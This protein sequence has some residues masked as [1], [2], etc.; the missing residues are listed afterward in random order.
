MNALIIFVLLANPRLDVAVAEAVVYAEINARPEL[1]D[2]FSPQ[3]SPGGD[4][5]AESIEATVVEEMP[6][7]VV[8]QPDSDGDASPEAAVADQTPDDLVPQPT[9]SS[10]AS[11]GYIEA[12]VIEELPELWMYSD[13]SGGCLPCRSAEAAIKNAT[14]PLPFRLVVIKSIP[15]WVT[16]YP[17]FHWSRGRVSPV[18]APDCDKEVGWN[19]LDSM[20]KRF[21]SSRSKPAG[22]AL[23][24]LGGIGGVSVELWFELVNGVAVQPT[25]THLLH[26]GYTQRQVSSMRYEDRAWF[27]GLSHQLE[28]RRK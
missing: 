1:P 25:D 2:D 21:T 9:P 3:P 28:A 14:T 5:S 8:S 15:Y 10:D 22:A 20:V 23:K 16:S 27:H 4:A 12:V 7:E 11:T 26:H 24:N 13:P 18:G 19:G 6:D 17:T